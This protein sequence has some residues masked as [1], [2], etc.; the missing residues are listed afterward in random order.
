MSL[1][2]AGPTIARLRTSAS[3]V[4]RIA[5]RLRRPLA[6]RTELLILFVGIIAAMSALSLAVIQITF[7]VA[8]GLIYDR[9]A[10]TLNLITVF[11]EDELRGVANLTYSI[12][13]DLQV[14]DAL[15]RLDSSV[16]PYDRRQAADRLESLLQ[17]YA[18]QVP[19]VASVHLLDLSLTV[20]SAGRENL[21]LPAGLKE[22]IA[23]SLRPT[24]GANQFFLTQPEGRYLIAGRLVR[25]IRNLSLAPI[26]YL[27]VRLNLKMLFD[28]YTALLPRGSMKIA[29]IAPEGVVFSDIAPIDAQQLQNL[30]TSA[31]SYAFL[32]IKSAR[33]LAVAKRSPYT[34]WLFVEM[35]DY[36]A[37][38]RN[39]LDLRIFVGAC[40]ILL[41]AVGALISLRF[42]RNITRPLEELT[43]HLRRVEGGSFVQADEKMLGPRTNLEILVLYRSFN[44]MVNRIDALVNDN[45]RK[46][47]QLLDSDF[48]ILQAQINPHFLYNTLD[49]I[50]WIAR[51]NHQDSISMMVRSL[52]NLLRRT[53]NRSDGIITLGEELDL[54]ESYISIQRVR[55]GNRLDFLASIG[56]ALRE[57]PVPRLTLQPIVENS[58]VHGLERQL[59]IC[60]IRITARSSGKAAVV[61]LTDTGPGMPPELL[62]RLSNGSFEPTGSGIGLMNIRERLRIYF[63]EEAH[64]EISS[65]ANEG[66]SV[67]L[68]IPFGGSNA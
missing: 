30:P 51:M 31:G 14:Q 23:E 21:I 65:R 48:R 35:L 10:E 43:G 46:K 4:R 37:V 11:V 54:V 53:L 60:A 19:S 56:G 59:G 24:D 49:S 8:N 28:P 15:E 12:A 39:T 61:T 6:M 50:N 26:G 25:R 17:P 64:I 55:F 40:I 20:Y 27:L 67:T 63:G 45:L 57:L 5:G 9:S 34:G 42:T 1:G 13:T 38:I 2:G 29:V 32:R 22:R 68:T 36:G 52:S 3:A 66:T 58:I 41:C 47:M 18:L 62:R 16:Q 44:L 33:Y 7:N